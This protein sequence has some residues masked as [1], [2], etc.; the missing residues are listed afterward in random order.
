MNTNGETITVMEDGTVIF[1]DGFTS[2]IVSAIFDRDG[3]IKSIS[4]V[5]PD[6][7]EQITGSAFNAHKIHQENMISKKT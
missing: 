3:N 5:H 4:F 7:G 1:F 6:T 2:S